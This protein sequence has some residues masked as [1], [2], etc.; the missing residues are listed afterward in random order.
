[1]EQD[2]IALLREVYEA[3]TE[4]R[5]ALLRNPGQAQRWLYERVDDEITRASRRLVDAQVA[6]IRFD[7]HSK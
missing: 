7:Q 3:S 5:G 6:V 4:F 2:E 1:M